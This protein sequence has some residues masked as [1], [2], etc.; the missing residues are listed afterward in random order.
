VGSSAFRGARPD[1]HGHRRTGSLTDVNSRDWHSWHGAYDDPNSWQARRLVTVRER[2]RVALDA[3]PPGPVVVLSL[4]AGEG[5]DLLPALAE[6]PRR[7]EV[8]ARLVELDPR[9]ADAARAT[10]RDLGL[11]GVEVITGDAALTDHYLGA[12]PAD[13]VLICGLFPHIADDDIATVAE[14]AASLTKRGGTVVWTQHRREPD[15]VPQISAWFAARGFAEDWITDPSV[16][17]AVVAHRHLA[18]PPP[19]AAGVKLF[20]FVGIQAL[21]PWEFPAPA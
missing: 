21:R 1:D 18:D 14:H 4:A 5:R 8:T 16:E 2:I 20:T 13:L 9:N 15:L 10:A 12:A 6:H 19:V 3:A 11:P 7:D 17:F